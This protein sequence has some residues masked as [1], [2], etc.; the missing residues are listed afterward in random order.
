[1]QT[2][3]NGDIMDTRIKFDVFIS[4]RRDGGEVLGRLLF[5]LLKNEYNV[6]FDHETLS[7]G[8]FDKKLLN[9]W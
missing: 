8:R 7:S 9:K 4:Y 2:K 1:M 6:F 3:G 5:E